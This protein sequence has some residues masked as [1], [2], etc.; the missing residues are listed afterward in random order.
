MLPLYSVTGTSAILLAGVAAYFSITGLGALY[1]ASFYTIIVMGTAIEISK[2]AATFWLHRNF[3]NHPFIGSIFAVVILLAMVVT[4]GG[5]YGY[6]TRGHLDQ[7]QPIAQ[8]E[9]QIDRLENQI[10]SETQNINREQSRLDQL[11]AII[12][13]LN[14]YDKISGPDGSRAVR[15][16]QIPERT[17]IQQSIDRSYELVDQYQEQLLGLQ[18]QVADVEG[19]LGPIKYLAVLFGLE[20]DQTVRYFT[21]LIV[22]LLDP[23]AIIL[24]IATSIA[25][26]RHQQEHG[27]L[28]N[29]PDKLNPIQDLISHTMEDKKD[30][31]QDNNTQEADDSWVDVL[32][33]QEVQDALSENPKLVNMVEDM[34]KSRDNTKRK[35]N[36]GDA[37]DQETGWA[38]ANGLR[39][40]NPNKKLDNDN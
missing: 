14:Q 38:T 8:A 37:K 7:K 19:K 39:F 18:S 2:L 23:F 10:L 31:T 29:L 4:S 15:E 13:T 30:S 20:P 21:L 28:K 32:N 24:V 36:V 25:Y 40:G 16:Q 1:A 6:L 9:L 11:D 12:A 27:K 3:K 5:V 26:T 22:I 35:P 34:I 17:D 33:D